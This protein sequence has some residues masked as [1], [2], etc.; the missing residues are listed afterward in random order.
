MKGNGR[1]LQCFNSL[2][3]IYFIAIPNRIVISNLLVL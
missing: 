1:Q 2:V 3:S